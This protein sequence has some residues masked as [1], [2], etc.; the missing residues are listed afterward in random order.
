MDSVT[1]REAPKQRDGITWVSWALLACN[2]RA[3][4]RALATSMGGSRGAATLRAAGRL[5]LEKFC[6]G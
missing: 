4:S 3:G 2:T 5:P 6:Y 1:Q